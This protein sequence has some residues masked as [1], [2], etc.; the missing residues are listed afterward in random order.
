MREEEVM[1]ESD[2]GTDNPQQP[3]ATS[4]QPPHQPS[5][6]H[7]QGQDVHRPTPYN[8]PPQQA[9]HQP[10]TKHPPPS[11]HSAGQHVAY[12]G[13]PDVSHSGGP[14]DPSLSA[15]LDV[16]SPVQLVGDHSR[17]GVIRWTGTLPEIKGYAVGVELVSHLIH[18]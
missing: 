3:P 13:R 5:R 2:F 11:H 4:D 17:T 14:L 16:G 18:V 15:G 1:L 8:S 9:V 12:A 6:P 7:R 10:N